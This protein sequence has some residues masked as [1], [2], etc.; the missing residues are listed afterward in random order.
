MSLEKIVH[1]AGM[2]ATS[3]RAGDSEEAQFRAGRVASEA[4]A[5]GHGDITR[6]AKRTV[7][8]LCLV[9]PGAGRLEGCLQDLALAMDRLSALGLY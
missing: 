7:H 9:A 8:C 2:L 6:A 1:A 4:E 5:L 3:L